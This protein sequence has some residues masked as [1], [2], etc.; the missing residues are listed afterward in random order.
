MENLLLTSDEAAGML[1]VPKATLFQW[2]HRR[3]IQFFKIGRRIFFK[4]EDVLSFI[5]N[6]RRP[7]LTA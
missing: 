6:R 2:T 5:E 3:E 7:A 1:R 4:T